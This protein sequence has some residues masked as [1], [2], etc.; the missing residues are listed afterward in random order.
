MKT[1][2]SII[3]NCIFWLLLIPFFILSM[4]DNGFAAST[5]T[6]LKAIGSA[7]ATQSGDYICSSAGLNR[8]HRFYIEV[9]SGL[10]NLYVDIYDADI[11]AVVNYTDW[12]VTAP[13]NTSCRYTLNRPNGTLEY[14]ASY[15]NTQ[16]AADSVWTNFRTV[17][18]PAA[19]HW[20]LVVDMSTTGSGGGDDT[21]GFGIR[22]H[23]GT[24]GAGGT[25]LP[26]YAE[27]FVPL[28]HIGVNGTYAITT[29][30][31]YVTSGCTVRWNDFDGDIAA[32]NYYARL[33]YD[34]RLSLVGPITYNGSANDVWLNPNTSITG[35][36]TDLLNVDMGIWTATARYQTLAT[37]TANFG[38]FWAGNWLT[39]TTGVPTAQPQTNSFRVYLPSD[40]GGAPVKP[41]LTQK[42]VYVSGPN[43][44]DHTPNP[45]TPT[46]LRVVINFVNPTARAVTFSAANLVTANVPA[47]TTRVVYRGPT[48]AAVS[49]GSIVTQPAAGGQ[50]NVT[51]NPGTVAAGA[52]VALYYEISVTPTA[53]GQRNVLTGI[54]TA[55]TPAINGT[56]A[57]Y[58][59][60]TGNTTQTRA[61]YTFG[62]LCELAATEGGTPIPTWVAVSCRKEEAPKVTVKGP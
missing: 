5:T 40:G 41:Y 8:P 37:S 6:T 45:H 52:Q 55:G 54:P 61:T 51:W 31:P 11:G 15:N 13:Y 7:A 62:P 59:D 46:Y 42:V 10:A 23:D 28:G 44:P 48:Y 25:E 17:S 47:T 18:N 39:G 1:K 32:P 30:Y 60:E 35:F 22:A 38:V 43:P 27:S 33:S 24:A 49:Q 29:F 57:K 36:R 53:N 20:E 16:I 34:S 2:R 3:Q 58:V 4:P 56:T 26:I 50:G 14:S 19:G 21:N 12:E 9:P